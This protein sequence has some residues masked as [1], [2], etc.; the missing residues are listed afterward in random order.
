VETR[1]NNTVTMEIGV[2]FVGSAPRLYSKDPRLTEAV[3]SSEVKWL[4][5]VSSVEGW[6]LSPA[7]QERL[8]R[9]GAIIG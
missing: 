3:Q 6:Q 9:D 7:L 1:H 8:R 4:V 2:F 5:R